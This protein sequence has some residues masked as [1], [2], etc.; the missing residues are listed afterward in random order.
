MENHIN[1][2]DFWTEAQEF[3][4]TQIPENYQDNL[5]DFVVSKGYSDNELRLFR[6]M[7]KDALDLHGVMVQLKSK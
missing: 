5:K 2:R 1:G 7:L 4:K 6:Y 3:L